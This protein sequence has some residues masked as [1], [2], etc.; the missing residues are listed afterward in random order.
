[1]A[2]D[3]PFHVC[4]LAQEQDCTYNSQCPEGQVC[5]VDG[6][7]RDQCASD[8]D[9]VSGQ[10]CVKG[11][12]ADPSELDGGQ[13]P[14]KEAEGGAGPTAPTPGQSCVYNSEC[15]DPLI[16]RSNLCAFECLAKADCATGTDCIEHR[17]LTPLAGTSE[18]GSGGEGGEAGGT[19]SSFSPPPCVYNSDCSDPLVCRSGGCVD[20]CRT[21]VD[22]SAG[23]A[24]LAKRCVLTPPA[25]APPDWGTSC[26]YSVD[27]TA[28]LVCR[29]NHCVYQCLSDGDCTPGF[30]C[31]SNL[32]QFNGVL[33]GVG[34][35]SSG[36][37][38]TSS[39]GTIGAGGSSSG[40]TSTGGAGTAGAGGSGVAGVCPPGAKQCVGN[41][42]QICGSDGNWGPLSNCTAEAQTCAAGTCL[43]CAAGTKN[44]DG[45]IINGCEV[46]L[47]LVGSCGSSCA[48]K[49]ACPNPATATC[50]AG[51]CGT[52]IAPIGCAGTVTP[53]TVNITDAAS[54]AAFAAAGTT[55]IAGDLNVNNTSLADLTGLGLLQW[56]GGN[57]SISGNGS[58]TSLKGLSGLKTVV[59]AVNIQSNAKLLDLSGLGSLATV[60]GSFQ[61]FNNNALPNVDGFS[62]LVKV[63]G[64][65][66]VQSNSSLLNLSG[67][68]ALTEVDGYLQVSSNAAQLDLKGFAALTSV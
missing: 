18:G 36:G 55:C 4:Q 48:D 31:T 45:S 16:C 10:E 56:I 17:C 52:A 57:V 43:P 30:S 51:A 3:R 53:G 49:V 26:S 24:C 22:C 20:E 29:S 2:S 37:G 39:G 33:G 59:G 54:A 66:N 41:A 40:A 50:L 34:G 6:Q 61:I 15:S 60:Q 35:A 7:C 65:L 46:N 62:S 63:Y 42:A 28:P 14:V 25:N 44:C 12:C 47:N 32:C 64:Y 1:M 11:N 58:M 67:F 27:C 9:C 23:E 8:R 19:S 5:G 38:A 13:L 21:S 68:P